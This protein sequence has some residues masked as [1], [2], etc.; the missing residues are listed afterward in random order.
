MNL[1]PYFRH[2]LTDFGDIWFRTS[3]HNVV[4]R[5]WVS[6]K[7]VQWRSRFI[8][9][10][11]Q[12]C[13]YAFLSLCQI[14]VKYG[15]VYLCMMPLGV[16]EFVKID[17][18]W[19]CW[20][21]SYASAVKR[22]DINIRNALVQRVCQDTVQRVCQDTVQRVCQ[23]TVQRVCRDIVQRLCQDTVRHCNL[24]V[25]PKNLLLLFWQSGVWFYPEPFGL[26]PHPPTICLIPILYYRRIFLGARGGIVVK[27]LC[28]K[29]AGRVFDS[30][31]C[32]WN[33]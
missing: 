10:H 18:E 14:C 27:T 12:M 33:F 1:Y 17:P 29:P 25:E 28:Y 13:Y 8:C 31:W 23:D 9:G 7:L 16:C 19:A 20:T 22:F 30:R 4:G 15:V 21:C 3:P 5:V 6:W 32:H 11:I 2:F 26:I 24:V